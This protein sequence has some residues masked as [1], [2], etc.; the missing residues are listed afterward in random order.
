S[1]CLNDTIFINV[2][3]VN[4]SPLVANESVSGPEDTPIPG[5]ITSND[6]DL[7]GAVTVVTTPLVNPKNGTIAILA[8]GNF[9][10]TPSANF[11]GKDTVVVS[12]CDNGSPSICLN[13]TIFINVTPV[14]NGPIANKDEVTT[15]E[16]TP[17]T[18]DVVFNDT[19]LD[20]FID[21]TTVK[22]KNQPKKGTVTVDPITGKI[23]YVPTSNTIGNDTL[24]YEVCDNGSPVLCDTALVVV[25]II[26]TDDPPIFITNDT[27]LICDKPTT[28]CF[29]TLDLDSGINTLSIL[30]NQYQSAKLNSKCLI[31]NPIDGFTGKDT[32]CVLVCN[33]FTCDTLK[34]VFDVVPKANNDLEET[35]DQTPVII[36]VLINDK[37]PIGGTPSVVITK[38][39][40][41]G[42]AIIDNKTG[43][44]LYVPKPGYCGLDTFYYK[45]C[46]MNNQCDSAMVVVD[47]KLKDSDKDG[48]PDYIEGED[49]LDGDGISNKLDLD[50]DNDGKLDS[51]ENIIVDPCNIK[52]VTDT[53]G[54]PDY[55]DFDGI[56]I[57]QGFS[58]NNDGVNDLFVIKNIDLYPK[59]TIYIYNRWG[60]M[61]YSKEGYFNDWNGY[62]NVQNTLGDGELPVGT[63]YYVLELN[64]DFNT[65][66]NGYIY[67]NK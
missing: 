63:Y 53:D 18:I 36:N 49:D 1:I 17:V 3:P 21:V 2:T 37:N 48:I 43:K 59:N 7:E 44:I 8:N 54:S 34:V 16:D 64:D 45:M 12:V 61:V 47:N 14:N 31:Y 46:D 10:Y 30:C 52:N 5:N 11:N 55:L 24:V 40:I 50:S 38:Q 65:K 4:D 42:K 39:A 56:F 9:T 51:E 22:I 41:K 57:P 23:N 15:N 35:D 62:P 60:N 6:S 66:Y 13:D 33:S 25:K 28:F 20:G 19:D 27:T 67:L 32:I 29:D 58:P 26:P